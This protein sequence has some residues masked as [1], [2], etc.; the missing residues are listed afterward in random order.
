[1]IIDTPDSLRGATSA[2]WICPLTKVLESSS[3]I[4]RD[5]RV[6]VLAPEREREP[7][8]RRERLAAERRHR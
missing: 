7:E 2:G 4:I 6:P 3:R 1:M 5:R 8:Q